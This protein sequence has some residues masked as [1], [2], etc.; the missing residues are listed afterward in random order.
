[1]LLARVAEGLAPQDD[2]D[3]FVERVVAQPNLGRRA[4]VGFDGA[5]DEEAAQEFVS[6][7]HWSV[8]SPRQHVGSIIDQYQVDTPVKKCLLVCY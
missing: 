2:G 3:G 7:H 8:S 6:C 4:G 5:E 1:M